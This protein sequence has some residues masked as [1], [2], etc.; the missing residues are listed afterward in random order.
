MIVRMLLLQKKKYKDVKRLLHRLMERYDSQ[1]KSSFSAV[2]LL[3]SMRY[4]QYSAH[5]LPY[6]SAEMTLSMSEFGMV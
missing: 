5:G 2:L 4:N 1:D 6:F 3:M